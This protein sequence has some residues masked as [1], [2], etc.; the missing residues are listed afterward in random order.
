MLCSI[1]VVFAA[2][3]LGLTFHIGNINFG[4]NRGQILLGL[5]RVLFAY[6][7][8]IILFRVWSAERW[9][10][11]LPTP[12]VAVLLLA[13]MALHVPDACGPSTSGW[14]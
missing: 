9:R 10:I 14:W 1:A 13:S 2:V 8:G 6:A 3:L 7:M 4:P 11:T 12:A 5:C